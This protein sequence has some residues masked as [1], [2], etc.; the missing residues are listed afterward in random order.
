MV[1]PIT[2]LVQEHLKMRPLGYEFDS[3]SLAQE[4]GVNSKNVAAVLTIARRSGWIVPTDPFHDSRSGPIPY[5]LVDK[6]PPWV[7]TNNR[8]PKP[9][10]KPNSRPRDTAKVEEHEPGFANHLAE[11][12]LE[13]AAELE[14]YV[15][16]LKD[17][18]T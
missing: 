16:D 6:T 8:K 11:R 9:Y 2:R 5:A 10:T 17:V 4:L 3:T 12:L 18:P 13:L 15:R 7:T 1:L 14:N